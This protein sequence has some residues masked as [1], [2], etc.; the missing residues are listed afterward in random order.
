MSERA[1]SFFGDLS[2][3]KFRLYSESDRLLERMK[4]PDCFIKHNTSGGCQIQAS[5]L[6]A[7]GNFQAML[8]VRG[9]KTFWQALGFA[10][11]NEMIA[12]LELL[13]PIGSFCFLRQKQESSAARFLAQGFE[14]R[15]CAHVTPVPIIH[16]GTAQ[17]LFLERK[18]QRLDEMK[19][20]ACSQA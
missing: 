13:G 19:P 14:R 3:F 8:R 12:M 7:H 9:E 1:G 5:G 2:C 16:A 4:L 15:P 18:P 11:E 6:L 20:R 17:R 10:P